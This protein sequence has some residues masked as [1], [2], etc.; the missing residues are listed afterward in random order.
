MNAIVPN[1]P[2]RVIVFDTTLRDGEQAPGFSL[3]VKDK[4]MLAHT[5]K[6]LGVDVIEAGFAASSPGDEEAIRTIAREVVGPTFCSLSRALESDIDAAA[7]ALLPAKRKR[8]HIF[9]AT[10]PIHRAAKLKK[11]REQVVEIAHKAVSYAST[12]FDEVEFS[13]EDAIRTEQDFLHE[14][15]I[16]AAEA[17]ARTLN[18]PDTVGYTTPKEIYQIFSD[19]KA[20]LKDHPQVIL[21]AHN[22][23]DL[24]L[25]VAN[26]LAAL[27]AGARQI[28]VTINGIGERAGNAALE[29]VV[30]ALR[31]RPELFKLHTGIHTPL[32]SK[33]SHLLSRATGTIVM[34]NKAVVGRNAFAHESGIHQHGMLTD[35]RTYEIMR[36]EDVGA[37]KSNLVLGKHSGRHAIAKQ[38]AAL[39]FDLDE[40]SLGDLFAAFKR[41]ADEIGEIDEFE[42]M[43]LLT[44]DNADKDDARLF[45]VSSEV[46]KDFVTITLDLF[47]DNGE[48]LKVT[49]TGLNAFEAGFRALVDAYQI[50]A[51]VNDC[52]IIQSGFT[53]DGGAFAEI[54]LQIKGEA[55]RGRGRGPDPVWAG[56]RA[57]CDAFEKYVFLH[58]RKTH[59]S[60]LNSEKQ[61]ETAR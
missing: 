45:K 35:A 23:D 39:G 19:L 30:M 59:A 11:T 26:T 37:E 22:H 43:S 13:P 31:T 51:R 49:A 14:V 28:E 36:P 41:R 12:I 24:G 4:L 38:A 7:R 57:M 46:T 53:F 32:L 20:A 52:E 34:R 15:C 10:S 9:L 48:P 25:G 8:C 21:S 16:A 33:A 40:L 44:R 42:L 50:E 56:L 54:S 1:D 60:N 3:G 27:E 18:I 55:Y 6:D 61:H 5:L 2:N 17:G 29:E 58:D 47:R